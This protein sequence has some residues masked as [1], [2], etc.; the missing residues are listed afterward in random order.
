MRR[1][2]A[3][4]LAL[5]LLASAC[6]GSA[7]DAAAATT[8]PTTQSST[9]STFASEQSTTTTT[10][11]ELRIVDTVTEPPAWEEVEMVTSDDVTLEG[12]L[13]PGDE[14]GVLVGHFANRS[15]DAGPSLECPDGVFCNDVDN[16]MQVSGAFARE[17]YTVLAI[18]FRNHGRSEGSYDL[19]AAPLD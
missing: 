6:G 15:A 7:D 18:S 4:L 9:S 19:K 2:A 16:W 5:S 1:I 8:A 12:R 3:A 17:G 13:W 14:R 11:P 10:I